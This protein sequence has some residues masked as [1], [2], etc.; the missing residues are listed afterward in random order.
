MWGNKKP[1]TPQGADPEPKNMQT[2]QPPKS[3]PES[4]GE[5]PR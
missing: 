5:Q 1:E 2:N 4:W 3:A